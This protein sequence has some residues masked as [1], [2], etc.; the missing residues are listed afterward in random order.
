MKKDVISWVLKG[1]AMGAADAVPG[2]SGGT[3]ALITGIYERFIC[4]LANIRPSLLMDLKRREFR[5]IWQKIDGNFLFFLGIGILISLFSMLNIMHWLLSTAAPT[6]WS[7]FLGV[8]LMS[9]WHLSIGRAWLIKDIVFLLMGL[10]IS[11][12]FATA[13]AITLNITPLILVLGGALAISA[14]L[15]PGISGSFM[16]LLLG[17]YPEVVE[18]VHDRN[19]SVVLWVALGCLLGILIFSRVL[20][21]LL[22]K[23]H[24]RVM[25]FML[26][27]IAGALVKVWPWQSGDQWFMPE[28]YATVTGSDSWFLLS[29]VT[30]VVGIAIVS[31]MY[32]WSGK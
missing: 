27:F 12:F 30:F 29:L 3:I 25:S 21:W 10:T 26:G 13:T 1:M 23:W 16:L 8:I 28:N 2:V 32:K 4:A 22:S 7:F 5:K 6:V 17:I 31:F 20:Q 15:L 14:M 18:A 11:V 24:E 19:F 9:L